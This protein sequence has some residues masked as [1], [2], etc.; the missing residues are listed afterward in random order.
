M[1]THTDVTN[2]GGTGYGRYQHRILV[3]LAGTSPAVVSETL[4]ALAQPDHRLHFIPTRI[5]V[6]TTTEGRSLLKECLL[7]PVARK[8]MGGGTVSWLERMAEDL[9]LQAPF[10]LSEA[11]LLVP[12]L[13]GGDEIQDAHTAEELDA[14]SAVMFEA[15]RKATADDQAAVFFSLSGGRKS[16]SHI[17]GQ[18]MTA[19]ARPQDKLLHVIVEPAWL[20]GVESFLY[21]L[22]RGAPTTSVDEE[23]RPLSV[24]QDEIVL[25]LTEEPFFRL[26][27]ALENAAK[28]KGLGV[29]AL[30]FERSLA[31]LSPSA[32]IELE[33]D[34][35]NGDARLDGLLLSFAYAKAG[36]VRA[37]LTL[38]AE[39][40]EL[41][42]PLR[43]EEVLALL[44]VQEV[45]DK[46]ERVQW[47]PE[48]RRDRV[49]ELFERRSDCS[50]EAW[51]GGLNDYELVTV[52]RLFSIASDG[53]GRSWKPKPLVLLGQDVSRLV[54]RWR[55]AIPPLLDRSLYEIEVD[56]Q[57][58]RRLPEFITI[59]F[60]Q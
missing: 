27:P 10:P 34:R 6:V 42:H 3:V 8:K 33:I 36:R 29:A 59:R 24:K 47:N 9:N 53:R 25:S 39:R 17:A 40:R 16:M 56:R 5:I 30:S 1:V 12:R 21:P 19:L 38:L 13:E 49:A 58:Y 46:D 52:V 11:D 60:R 35:S 32:A 23:G 22:P 37:Y 50:T 44:R 41:S 54:S 15:L 4:F 51:A 18:C 20:E 45:Q 43:D 14:M 48:W 55:E 26:R 28:A 2:G 7:Q 31:I 57:G